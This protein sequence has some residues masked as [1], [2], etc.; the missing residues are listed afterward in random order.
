MDFFIISIMKRSPQ[1]HFGSEIL[2]FAVSFC[3]ACLPCFLEK[4]FWFL[5]VEIEDRTRAHRN[6]YKPETSES[7]KNESLLLR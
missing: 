2:R 1:L 7:I 6:S 3:I 5:V 4:G